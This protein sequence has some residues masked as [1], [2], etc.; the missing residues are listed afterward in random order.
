MSKKYVIFTDSCCDLSTEDRKELGVEFVRMGLVINGSEEKEADIDW[1]AYSPEE[2]YGWLSAGKK[3]KT[4]QVSLAEFEKRFTPYLEKGFD[5]LYLGCS[6]Q[7]SGSV[8]F[9]KQIAGPGLEA[10]FPGRKVVA[11]DTCAAAYT[12]GL[13][14]TYACAQKSAGKSLE[15]VVAWL[16]EHKD[17][18][19]QFATVDTMRYLKE[20]G[21]IKGAKAFFGDLFQKKPIFISDKLGNNLTIKVVSGTKQSLEELFNGVKETI[22]TSISKEV[23]ICQGMAQARAEFLKKRFEDELGLNVKIRWIGPIVGTTC[24]PGIIATF[25]WGKKVTRVEGDGLDK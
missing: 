23:I 7:L 1:E 22:D 3:L 24:G 12:E 10:K 9:C 20:A 4:T 11:Y 6:N 16:D 8:N 18:A 13:V 19:N 5:I 25:C 17:E 21:R 14:V 2:F 15:E